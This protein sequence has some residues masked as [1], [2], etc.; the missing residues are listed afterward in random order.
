MLELQDVGCPAVG[1]IVGEDGDMLHRRALAGLLNDLP[2]PSRT[3]A[4]QQTLG[5][6]LPQRSHHRLAANA[7]LRNEPLQAREVCRPMPAKEPVTQMDRC[8]LDGGEDAE[9]CHV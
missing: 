5:L 9:H 3:L 2:L 4:S 6:K 7:Q 1:L 8:L